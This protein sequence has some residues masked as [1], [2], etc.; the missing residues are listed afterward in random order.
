MVTVKAKDIKI[1]NRIFDEKKGYKTV[2]DILNVTDKTIRLKLE[3]DT[4]KAYRV[5]T[6]VKINSS[7][8]KKK[9]DKNQFYSLKNIMM[10][11]ADYNIIF[12]ERSNGKTFACLEHIVKEFVN[13]GYKKQGAYI[14]RFREDIIGKRAEQ[15]FK[16]LSESG[17]IEEI[18]NGDF[19]SVIYSSGKWYL[20]NFDIQLRKYVAFETPLCF[21][22]A[23]SEMEHDK[24]ASYPNVTT[25]VFDEFLTRKYYLTDEFILFLNVLSTIIRHRSNVQIFMLGNTVNKFCPYFKEMGLKHVTKMEQGTIDIYRFGKNALTIAVE[26]TAPSKVKKESNKY[27][28]FDDSESVQMIVNGKWEMAIY[29]HLQTKFEKKDIIFTYFIEFGENILQCEIV[30]KGNEN[31]TYIHEKTTPIKDDDNDLIYSLEHNQK[32]NYKRRL[33]ART[34][35]LEKQIAMYYALEK[36]FFQ[37][38]EV[39]EIVRNYILQSSQSPYIKL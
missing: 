14:R 37:N 29:P 2:I 18:T 20:A 23:L 13:S 31:F 27:F 33:L 39:G 9:T 15:I 24:S 7:T 32:A 8:K 22:F 36:V 35:K 19:T 26:Y 6:D 17:K 16:G 30:S 1:G 28:C 5:T 38:N 12:G 34:T 3:D 25:V 4:I 21:S 10:K 11:N